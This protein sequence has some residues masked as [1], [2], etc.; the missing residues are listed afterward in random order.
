M[1]FFFKSLVFECGYTQMMDS[2]ICVCIGLLV[3]SFVF[4]YRILLYTPVGLSSRITIQIME[5]QLDHIL[6][7]GTKAATMYMQLE[8]SLV[9]STNG[10]WIFSEYMCCA[11]MRDMLAHEHRHAT[12]NRFI[13][14]ILPYNLLNL[15]RRILGRISNP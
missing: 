14:S 15:D 10:N 6:F 4:L 2:K 12:L 1:Y 13:C 3:I 9:V 11:A 8:S 7:S 5:N